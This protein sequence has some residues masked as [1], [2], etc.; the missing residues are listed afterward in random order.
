MIQKKKMKNSIL[1]LALALTL[2]S[3]NSRSGQRKELKEA[4]MSAE[5]TLKQEKWAVEH[6]IIIRFDGTDREIPKD[7]ELLVIK[8]S[9]EDTIIVGPASDDDCRRILEN[10]GK[11]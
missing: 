6:N 4:Q 11:G 8:A 7:G 1:I 2:V 9:L 5:K 3:C 10:H